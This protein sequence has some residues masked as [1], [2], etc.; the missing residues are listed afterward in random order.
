MKK[1]C[2]ICI[3]VL[4]SMKTKTEVNMTEPAIRN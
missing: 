1:N 3:A 4:Y 2:S